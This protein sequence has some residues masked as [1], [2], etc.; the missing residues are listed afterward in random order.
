MKLRRCGGI[1]Q[2]HAGEDE[3]GA[4]KEVDGNLLAEDGPGKDD[5]GDGIEIDI[6]GG[7]DVTYD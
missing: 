6:V 1:G 3:D 7:D 5:R 4:K 2:V